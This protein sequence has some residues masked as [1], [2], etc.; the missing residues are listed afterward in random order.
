VQFAATRALTSPATRIALP[1]RNPRTSAGG[2][3]AFVHQAACGG[4]EGTYE[5]ATGLAASQGPGL[6]TNHR[7]WTSGAH[8]RSS[9]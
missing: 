5:R 3:S 7:P 4:Y 1:L 9:L 2:G 6:K 8:V